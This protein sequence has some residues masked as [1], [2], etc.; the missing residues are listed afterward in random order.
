MDAVEQPPA[1]GLPLGPHDLD[2]L[3]HPGIRLRTRAAEVVERPED[4]VVPVIREREVEV[5]R[6]D[7]LSRSQAAEQAP[8]EQIL[9]PTSAGFPHVGGPPGGP[10]ELDQPVEH[11]DRRVER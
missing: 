1:V 7:D 4:V 3:R 5:R 6:I 8:L 11:V 9:L 10:L 2:R